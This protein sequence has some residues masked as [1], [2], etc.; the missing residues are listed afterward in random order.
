MSYQRYHGNYLGIVVQNN[1][2]QKR[3]RVKVFVPHISSTVYQ[4]WINTKTDK[5]FKFIGK[6]INSDLGIIL[7]DLKKIL[8][9]A[10]LAIPLAGE[11]SSGRYNANLNASTISDSGNLSTAITNLSSDVVDYSKLT[12]YSQNVDNIGEKPGNIFDISYFKLKDAFSNPEETNINNVNRFSYNYTP[13]CYSNSARG[14][15]PIISVG[16]HVW[17]FFNNGDPNKPVIFGTSF[18][19]EDWDS[20]NSSVSGIGLDYPGAYENNPSLSN[21]DYDI[22][23]ETYRNK[24]V[25]N[26]KGGTISFVNTDNREILKLTHYSGSF[27]EFNNFTNIEFASNN[28]QSLI[29]GDDFSTVRGSR[30]IFTQLDYD[31]VT[32]GDVFKKVGNLKA[33]LFKKWKKQLEDIADIKQL[34]DIKR[35][36]SYK[37]I[38]G[39]KFTSSKQNQ[40]NGS[41]DSCP[42]CSKDTNTYFNLNNSYSES[43]ENYV[44][45]SIANSSGDFIFSKSVSI[46]GQGK[47]TVKYVGMLGKVIQV[48]PASG[49]L[50]TSVDGSSSKFSGPGYIMGL[51]CPVCNPNNSNK[52]NN[53]ILGKSTSS[54]GGSWELD[55]LK[56]ELSKMY[57][58]KVEIL[59]NLEKQMGIGGSEIIE[60]TKHKIETIGLVMNDF[61]S[62]RVD[63]KGKMYISEVKVGPYGVFYNRTP[64]PLVELV[65]VDD[66][67]GGTYNLNVANKYSLLVGA[68]GI[69][70]KSYGVVNVSGSLTNI[71]GEQVNISSELE[72]NIDGGKRLS[73]V[74]DVISIRQRD[75]KQVV[76]EGSLGVTNNVVVAGGLHVEG[77]ITANHITMPTEIQATEQTKVYGAAVTDASNLNGPIIGFGVPLSQ[78]P[79]PGS[80]PGTFMPKAGIIKTGPPYLGLLDEAVTAGNIIGGTAH[81]VTFTGSIDALAGTFTGFLTFTNNVPVKGSGA[82]CVKAIEHG[83]GGADPRQMAIVVYGTG[84]DP[85]SI[86]MEPH[87]HMYKTVPTRLTNTNAE[88]REVAMDK[89]VPINSVPVSNYKR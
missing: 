86:A 26:Q 25:I 66:L 1:D 68:G 41:F 74:G 49:V 23:V 30:N 80:T 55:P 79:I 78:F 39:L 7:D 65:H 28:N 33:D 54:Q 14:S 3:G 76:V 9:W 71:S 48:T 16:S 75:K 73:L 84:R 72:T 10:E 87:S 81:A 59:A 37:S 45:G 50:G 8:P 44:V 47:P 22:N 40:A 5:K 64:T 12:Q 20:I 67:P 6:N 82:D 61:P 31:C 18:G 70:L 46:K 51:P 52:N 58:D 11:S 35:T 60:I 4:K 17:I 63:P 15:F 69:N 29:L 56:Q 88:A 89:D 53:A 36:N 34:F 77:E 32:Q 62:I 24:Y 85:D 27:K 21:N 19:K 38:N 57:L 2:P 83:A 13:E 42:V 43:F